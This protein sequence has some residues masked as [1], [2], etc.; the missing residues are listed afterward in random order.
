MTVGERRTPGLR[1]DSCIEQSHKGSKRAIIEKE[2]RAENKKKKGQLWWK[3]GQQKQEFKQLKF[4][5]KGE[6]HLNRVSFM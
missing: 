5:R 6:G 1:W 3:E 2:R 4:W